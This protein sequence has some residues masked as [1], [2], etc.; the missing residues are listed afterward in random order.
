MVLPNG[1]CSTFY[2]NSADG[3]FPIE[4]PGHQRTRMMDLM[5]ASWFDYH[6]ASMRLAAAKKTSGERGVDS[7]P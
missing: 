3:R 1:G 4:S 6:V 2:K 7:R 5:K